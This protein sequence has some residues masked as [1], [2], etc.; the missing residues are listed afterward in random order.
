MAEPTPA[1][2]RRELRALLA[3]WDYAFAM[4]ARRTYGSDPRL[5]GVLQ[6]V[7]ELRAQLGAGGGDGR[8]RPD[9]A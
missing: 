6:R 2:L 9:P 8:P 1:E 5:D 3:S 7:A 4:G